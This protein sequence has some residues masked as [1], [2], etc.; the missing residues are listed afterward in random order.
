MEAMAYTWFNRL[1]AIRYMEHHLLEHGF[2]VL[3]HPD[4]HAQQKSWKRLSMLI[5]QG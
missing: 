2:R 3:S 5:C 4:G 1:V